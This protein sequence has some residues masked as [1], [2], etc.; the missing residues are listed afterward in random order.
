M[1]EGFKENLTSTL[2]GRNGT[3][4]KGEISDIINQI[5]SHLEASEELGLSDTINTIKLQSEL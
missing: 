5:N 1:L 3:L 4:I 2:T